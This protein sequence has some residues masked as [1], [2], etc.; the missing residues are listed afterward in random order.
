MVPEMSK[1][2]VDLAPRSQLVSRAPSYPPVRPVSRLISVWQGSR[3]QA[4]PYGVR[5]GRRPRRLAQSTAESVVRVVGVVGVVRCVEGALP[6]PTGVDDELG[7]DLRG[8]GG[9]AHGQP[10]D[11]RDE[12]AVV[13]VHQEAHGVMTPRPHLGLLGHDNAM[14]LQ[15][16]R[17][18]SGWR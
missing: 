3:Q 18:E 14:Q 17:T 8:H 10:L 9:A 12:C 16:T 13:G 4:T 5:S 7:T 1:D 11:R 2:R 15:H 6:P